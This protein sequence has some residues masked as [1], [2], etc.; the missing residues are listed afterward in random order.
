LQFQ[1]IAE[2]TAKN[3]VGLSL[4]LPHTALMFYKLCDYHVN[5]LSSFLYGPSV[6]YR[7]HM[8]RTTSRSSPPNITCENT[9][10]Y[11]VG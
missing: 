6:C 8:G 2:K 4:F 5:E 9:L 3:I 7:V 1:A 10:A 11:T